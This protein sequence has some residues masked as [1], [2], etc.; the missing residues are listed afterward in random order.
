MNIQP[1]WEAIAS[2][3]NDELSDDEV[4]ATWDQIC[5]Q[6]LKRVASEYGSDYRIES[7]A[8]FLI[9]SNESA[10]YVDVFSAFLERTLKRILKAL[11]GVAN[12]EGNGK[13][14]AMIF[15]DAD[16][17]YHYISRFYPEDGE[18]GL[19]SGLYIN[20]GYGHFAFPS[21]DINYAETIAVHELTHA[22]LAHLDIPL[23]L[24]EGLAVLMEEVLAG[25]H[26]F[27]D[28][29][30]MAK[31]QEYWNT[32]TIQGFW[33]GDSFF[34]TDE[35]QSLSYHLAHVLTRKLAKGAAAFSEFAN[36]ANAAD[37]GAAA[38]EQLGHL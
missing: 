17:Y 35:G 10:R 30:L 25:Q 36:H 6:W 37:A 8:N 27:I 7:T 23:W 14:V 13:H 21:Q 5:Q 26:L 12:D 38:A 24:N 33:S 19:S 28:Q 20:E 11:N 18:F 29:E 32:E 3:I 15:K 34:A 16:D 1:D 31:H 2:N 9:L 4:N 22:C